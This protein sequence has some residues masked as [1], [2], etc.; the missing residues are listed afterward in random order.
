VVHNLISRVVHFLVDKSIHNILLQL[1]HDQGIIGFTIFILLITSK[2]IYVKRTDI[3]FLLSIT[4]SLFFPIIFQ[5][6]LIAVAF[7]WPIIIHSIL[8]QY[9]RLNKKGLREIFGE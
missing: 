8:I 4:F 1:L 6:G 2:V 5:N 9:S 7:W 3:I